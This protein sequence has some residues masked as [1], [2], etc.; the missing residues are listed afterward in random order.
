MPDAFP[1]DFP[2]Y[3]D[4]TIHRGDT[5]GNRFAIDM[6]AD[7]PM[8]DVVNFYRQQL[9]AA[10]WSITSDKVDPSSVIFD[11]NA[12]DGRPYTGQVAVAKLQDLTWI[13]IA[14]TFEQ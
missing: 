4:V 12:T 8:E 9:A 13:L 1:T 6:R 7:V 2:V 3:A 14:M 11:F 10:P 5:I